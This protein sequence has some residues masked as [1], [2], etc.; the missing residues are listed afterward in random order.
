MARAEAVS[1][2]FSAAGL[3]L[4]RGRE[5]A[6]GSSANAYCPTPSQLPH[7]APICRPNASTTTDKPAPPYLTCASMRGLWKNWKLLLTVKIIRLPIIKGLI[8]AADYYW[9]WFPTGLLIAINRLAK[10]FSNLYASTFAIEAVSRF[11]ICIWRWV[12]HDGVWKYLFEEFSRNL[13]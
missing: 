5:E 8:S 7:P 10:I 11:L 13:K 9:Y 6:Q 2:R 3:G 12:G 1:W 4:S